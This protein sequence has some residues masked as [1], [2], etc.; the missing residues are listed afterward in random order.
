[1]KIR[2]T[3]EQIRENQL[4]RIKKVLDLAYNESDFYKRIYD[5]NDLQ[6]SFFKLKK[7]S[8]KKKVCSYLHT[9]FI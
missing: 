6:N 1:M 9:F 2:K 7:N 3:Q 5:V 8:L 4:S